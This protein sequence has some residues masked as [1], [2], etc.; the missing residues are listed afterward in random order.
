MSDNK[1][2]DFYPDETKSFNNL[3]NNCP[4]QFLSYGG[5]L[6][7]ISDRVKVLR[8]KKRNERR[9]FLIKKINNIHIEML[10]RQIQYEAKKL[11]KYK[12]RQWTKGGI[13]KK[14]YLKFFEKNDISL[15]YLEDVYLK[16]MKGPIE[17]KIG[18][19]I[20]IDNTHHGKYG[21]VI[22]IFPKLIQYQCCGENYINDKIVPDFENYEYQTW[23]S[24]NIHGYTVSI[25]RCIKIGS[26]TV[27]TI[28]KRN[29]NYLIKKDDYI[30]RELFWI[31]HI[32]PLSNTIR[33]PYNYYRYD[34][35]LF[36]GERPKYISVDFTKT[37]RDVD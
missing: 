27:E 13:N 18:D 19:H 28:Q 21:I 23:G 5:L 7:N 22:K 15:R 8:K 25:W 3:P 1:S 2:K 24:V 33:M 30:R 20:S 37:L 11:S 35:D 29:T 10:I 31:N 36:K 32:K 9:K 16:Q 12:V 34:F 17:L 14:A 26:D 4:L 6:T